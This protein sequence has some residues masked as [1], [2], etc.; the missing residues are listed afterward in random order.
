MDKINLAEA[1]TTS[2]KLIMF[3]S[4]L[5]NYG[6]ERNYVKYAKSYLT[7]TENISRY[8]NSIEL[9]GNKALSVLASGDQAFNLIY[10]G[11]S[12][13]DT[14]DINHLTYFVFNLRRALFMGLDKK[15]AIKAHRIFGVSG[16]LEESLVIL[17]KIKGF[18]PKEVYQYYSELLEF[19]FTSGIFDLRNLFENGTKNLRN[20][21]L[22]LDSNDAYREFQRGLEHASVS[23]NFG[24]VANLVENIVQK[25]DVI[26][27]SNIGDYLLK[28]PNFNRAEYRSFLENYLK[29]LQDRGTLVTFLANKS[30]E[31]VGDYQ[32]FDIT[33]INSKE[34]V[35]ELI[36]K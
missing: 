3:G 22:Y 7:T 35:Y 8:L 11:F 26:I 28:N 31:K 15:E 6:D 33:S 17:E 32:D 10:K 20:Y 12:E 34:G 21:N 29:I 36:R 18:M 24:D 16:H 5:L 1:I 2:K 23:F 4:S 19:A 14:F 9:N 25:Y 30:K 27:L 13:I